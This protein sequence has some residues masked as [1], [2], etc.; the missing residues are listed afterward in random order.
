MYVKMYINILFNHTIRRLQPSPCLKHAD[1]ILCL[2]LYTPVYYFNFCGDISVIRLSALNWLSAWI[3]KANI[4]WWD[5]RHPNLKV[6]HRVWLYSWRMAGQSVRDWGWH[7]PV[8]LK[9][10]YGI[11]GLIMLHGLV[12]SA[13]Y[14][15]DIADILC[16]LYQIKVDQH[17]DENNFFLQFIS[18]TWKN[19]PNFSSLIPASNI[20]LCPLLCSAVPCGIPTVA[21]FT[22]TD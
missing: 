4:F 6:P 19:Y 7:A 8:A 12:P 5:M 18:S 21:P 20:E 13:I 10:P 14:F 9:G 15:Y 16:L 17:S 11:V 22:K 1:A 2:T 3:Q